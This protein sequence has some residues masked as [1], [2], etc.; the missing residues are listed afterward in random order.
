MYFTQRRKAGKA[1]YWSI[2]NVLPFSLWEKG[3]GD[4]AKKQKKGYSFEHPYYYSKL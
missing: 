1:D 3:S 4:E 2:T